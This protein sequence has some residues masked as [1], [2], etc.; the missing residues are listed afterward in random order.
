MFITYEKTSEIELL[1]EKSEDKY[2]IKLIAN[3]SN[4][5]SEIIISR[6]QMQEYY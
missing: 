2:I 6:S 5:I 4:K 3:D 1:P